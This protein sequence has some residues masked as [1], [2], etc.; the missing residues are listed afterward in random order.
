VKD[1]SG[2]AVV[3]SAVDFSLLEDVFIVHMDSAESSQP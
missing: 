2:E 1:I 3:D